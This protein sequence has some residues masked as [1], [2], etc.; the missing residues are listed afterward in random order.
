MKIELFVSLVAELTITIAPAANVWPQEH[1]EDIVIRRRELEV[2][3]PSGMATPVQR[4][5]SHRRARERHT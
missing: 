2:A 1:K 4:R 3:S 5:H